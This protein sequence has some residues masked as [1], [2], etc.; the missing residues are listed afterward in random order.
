MYH[1]PNGADGRRH[2]GR[3]RAATFRAVG[4]VE[5]AAERFGTRLVVVLGHTRCGAV[6]RQP[7][8]SFNGQPRTSRGT[9]ARSSTAM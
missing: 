7:P 5:L 3:D 6:Q 9:C 1:H 2:V 4:G 8:R